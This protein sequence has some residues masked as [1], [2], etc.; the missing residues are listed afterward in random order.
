MQRDKRT[1]TWPSFPD[2]MLRF[3][4]MMMAERVRPLIL[5]VSVV[6]LWGEWESWTNESR[7]MC[8]SYV[9]A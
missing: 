5:E 9:F 3:V 8:H 2:V 1:V 7:R 4:G 6:A